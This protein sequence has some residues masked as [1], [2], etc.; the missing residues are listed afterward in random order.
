MKVKYKLKEIHPK[1]FLVTIDN[2][3]DLAM[4]FC[5]VQEFYESP[6]KEIRGKVF[7]IIEFQ[8]LYSIKRNEN[9][10][11]YPIDWSGF[12]IP[13]NVIED[14]FDKFNFN[15]DKHDYNLYDKTFEDIIFKIANTLKDEDDY[16]IIA[17]EPDNKDTINHEL[18]HAFYYLYP[19][20]KKEADKIINKI[21]EPIYN[22]LKNTLFDLGYNSKVVKDEIQAYLA[23]DYDTITQDINLNKKNKII[24]DKVKEELKVLS[25]KMH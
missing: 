21:P 23:N 6:Y 19:E 14:F 24:I 17:S 25:N 5:R 16:Y 11:S 10:F 1:V 13:S 18:S 22:K 7:N 8:R 15:F 3:Y 20:Y 2:S 9:F 4:T 12:N